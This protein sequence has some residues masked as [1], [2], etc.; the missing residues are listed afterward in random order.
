MCA[1]T[2]GT[3]MLAL[4]RGLISRLSRK[5]GNFLS[6]QI[7]MIFGLPKSWIPTSKK[8]I[9][10]WRIQ[11]SK[12]FMAILMKSNLILNLYPQKCIRNYNTSA[13][14]LECHTVTNPSTKCPT[15]TSRKTSQTETVQWVKTKKM[16]KK[17]TLAQILIIKNVKRTKIEID[18]SN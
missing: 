3:L 6:N 14:C 9:W 4:T 2:V 11:I 5:L 18:I 8:T 10:F 1:V 17:L 7:L 15:S 13:M 16:P 12:L